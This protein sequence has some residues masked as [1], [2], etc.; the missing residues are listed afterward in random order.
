MCSDD[1]EWFATVV[2]AAKQH[3]EMNW[4]RGML[5]LRVV[6]GEHP[7]TKG[8]ADFEMH[9]EAFFRLRQAR[10]H[11]QDQCGNVCRQASHVSFSSAGVGHAPKP[12]GSDTIAAWV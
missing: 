2:G 6:D 9:D 1:S 3:G 8:L 11:K 7:I 10:N 12:V 4:S 5:K